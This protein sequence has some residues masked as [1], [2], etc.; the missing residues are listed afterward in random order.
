MSLAHH[1][2]LAF[3]YTNKF[4]DTKIVFLIKILPIFVNL[5]KFHL[6]SNVVKYN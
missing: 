1:I 6:N 2:H 4:N 3:M 5:H